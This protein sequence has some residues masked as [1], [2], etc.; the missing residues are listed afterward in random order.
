MRAS[1]L[2]SKSRINP[3]DKE[4]LEWYDIPKDYDPEYCDLEWLQDD[5]EALWLEIKEEM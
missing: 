2:P 3:E 1:V 4:R 5:V